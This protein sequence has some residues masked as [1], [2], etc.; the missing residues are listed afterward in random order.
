MKGD[1]ERCQAAGMNDYLSK[2]L[3]RES[4]QVVLDRF[5]RKRRIPC[6]CNTI[7]ED[8]LPIEPAEG[9]LI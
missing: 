5:L 7:D 1:R 4:I 9:Q 6:G 2:P 3:T 8:E